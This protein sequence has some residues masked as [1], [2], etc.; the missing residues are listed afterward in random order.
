MSVVIVYLGSSPLAS[1]AL[2]GVVGEVIRIEGGE[3][4]L[5]LRFGGIAAVFMLC[6]V[7]IWESLELRRETSCLDGLGK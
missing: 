1:S 4:L 6:K 2:V 3:E 5:G 7:I